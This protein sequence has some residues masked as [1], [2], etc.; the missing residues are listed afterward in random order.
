LL[1]PAF[2]LNNQRIPANAEGDG[3][4]NYSAC[5]SDREASAT[6]ARPLLNKNHKGWLMA[7]DR[8]WIGM[9]RELGWE[10]FQKIVDSF[11]TPIF[12]VFRLACQQDAL[13]G[14]Q[15]IGLVIFQKRL[16]P[17]ADKSNGVST[18]CQPPDAIG[19]RRGGGKWKST[20]SVPALNIR[21]MPAADLHD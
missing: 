12:G 14:F 20:A 15:Q 11:G 10:V 4:V 13:D 8:R 18:R 19:L 17:M 9:N 16:P 2:G 1:H 21:N 7:P 5:W 6:A 3:K